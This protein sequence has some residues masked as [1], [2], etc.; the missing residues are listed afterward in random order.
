MAAFF[1]HDASMLARVA[2]LLA[3]IAAA[4]F[5]LSRA[6]QSA[7]LRVPAW[8]G[9]LAAAFAADRLTFAA[10]AGFRMIVLI[11]SLLLAMKGIVCL[12][13]RLAGE[14]PLGAG[15][16][17][18]F[19]LGWFGMRPAAF[20][21]F[22][23]PARAGALEYLRRG[24]LSTALGA[25]LALVARWSA[26][27]L[28]AAHG[29]APRE[30]VGIASMMVA[31]SLTVHFGLFELQAGLWRSLGAECRSLFR[32]PL[33][34]ASLREFWG[35][36]WNLAFSE[37]S[38]I[39]LFRPLKPAVGANA[40]TIAAFLFSGL[41]HEAAISLPVRAGFGLP[42]LYFALHALAM[43]IESRRFAATFARRPWLGRCWTL[44]WLL[45]PLPFLFHPPFVRGVIAP[46]LS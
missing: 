24:V 10:P 13:S 23:G 6:R 8:I 43:Q 21:T 2:F 15:A 45:L 11:A 25:A 14:P 40:A 37:M 42:L 16:W 46:L 26:G 39:A 41:L 5:A 3:V 30:L 12:E 17:F 18:A 7:W 1:P 22:P 4:A 27:D 9:V 20:A 38:A 36:R 44:A 33:R 34:S 19:V 32:A 29:I 28:S 35:S 31:F